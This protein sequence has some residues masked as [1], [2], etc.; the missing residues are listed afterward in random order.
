MVRKVKLYTKVDWEREEPILPSASLGVEK[1]R[2]HARRD[3]ARLIHSPSFRRL[4]GKTQLFPSHES[5]FFRNRLTHSLEVAQIAKSI[6]IRLNS[7]L[8]MFRRNPIN[9]D[10]V[11]FAGLAHDLGHPP[12]GHNGESTLDSLMLRYGGFEGNAQTLRLLARIEKKATTEF[13]RL[14]QKPIAVRNG[15]DLRLGLNLSHRSL[16]SILKY[17]RAIPETKSARESQQLEKKPVKGYYHSEKSLVE[18]IKEKVC[19]GYAGKFKTIEC[20]IMDIADD[21]AYSTYDLEDAFKARFLSPLTMMATDDAFKE[22]IAKKVRESIAGKSEKFAEEID[23]F[24]SSDVNNILGEIFEPLLRIEPSTRDRLSEGIT[25]AELS[26][27]IST[28]TAAS[29]NELAEN[30]FLRTSFTSELVGKFIRGISAEINEEYPAM[31]RINID[32][33]TLKKIETLKHFVFELLI[34]SPMLKIAEKRGDQI[35]RTLFESFMSDSKLLPADWREMYETID[36]ES[37]QA[38]VVC[39]YIAG[40]TDRYCVEMYARLTSENPITIWKPH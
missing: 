20:D 34:L 13:P 14:S 12:F 31:S 1:Y 5:D 8:E 4:Q 33:A 17:D 3:Y 10:L 6:A 32:I 30:G 39:D 40:M 24:A 22:R 28:H 35:I 27:R 23:S 9:L 37:W 26:Y 21:I 19:P 11:E 38:R 7:N 2:E 15:Q 16:A 29:S 18:R 25:P 36:S